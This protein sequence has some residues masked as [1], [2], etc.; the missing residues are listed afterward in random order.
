VLLGRLDQA[1]VRPPLQ[2]LEADETAK[3]KQ[4]LVA[5]GLQN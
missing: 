4:A 1:I 3:L 5:A 2:K